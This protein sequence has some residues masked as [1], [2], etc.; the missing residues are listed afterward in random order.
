MTVGQGDDFAQALAEIGEKH[1]ADALENL[2]LL[3]AAAAGIAAG[4]IDPGVRDEARSAAHK[5]RGSFGVFGLK[6][7]GQVAGLVEDVLA[8]EGPIPQE[9]AS[10]VERAVQA[11]RA[12]LEE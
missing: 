10:E 11:L 4:D 2:A 3:E 5:L 6:R 9:K 8:A 1:R 12:E 7:A